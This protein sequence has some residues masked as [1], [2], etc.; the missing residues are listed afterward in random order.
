M[1]HLKDVSL[2]VECEQPNESLIKF[3]GRV[4]YSYNPSSPLPPPPHMSPD[5]TTILPL[6]I[7][8]LI[9]RGSVL[10]NTDYVYA[11]VVYTGSNTRIMKNLK[12]SGNKQS[13]LQNWVNNLVLLALLLNVLFLMSSVLLEFVPYQSNFVKYWYIFQFYTLD[14]PVSSHLVYFY[15]LIIIM[16]FGGRF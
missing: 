1:Q 2:H 7:N 11:V 4:T 10:R 3:D 13:R 6:T 12:R 15:S 16:F 14:S 5:P 9:L 8:N